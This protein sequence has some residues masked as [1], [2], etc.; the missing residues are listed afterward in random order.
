MSQNLASNTHI[1]ASA[2]IIRQAVSDLKDRRSL[3]FTAL[4]DRLS[5]KS[6]LAHIFCGYNNKALNLLPKMSAS[7]IPL[8][9]DTE[10]TLPTSSATRL[11]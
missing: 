11:S 8:I 10:E 7:R 4:F 9:P 2:L 1:F 6:L 5:P 3:K